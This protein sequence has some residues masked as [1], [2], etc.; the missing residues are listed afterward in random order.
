MVTVT[1]GSG[2]TLT[3]TFNSQT[4]TANASFPAWQYKASSKIWYRIA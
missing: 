4:L 2:D 1:A 3:T